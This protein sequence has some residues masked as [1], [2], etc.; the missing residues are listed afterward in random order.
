MKHTIFF[1]RLDGLGMALVRRSIERLEH[2]CD[3]GHHCLR[4]AMGEHPAFRY[5]LEPMAEMHRVASGALH[6]IT[7]EVG[8]SF[9]P[10]PPMDAPVCFR[11]SDLLDAARRHDVVTLLTEC[12]LG[13]R[14]LSRVYRET[15]DAPIPPH[16][17]AEI[18]AQMLMVDQALVQLRTLRESREAIPRS[19]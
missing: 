4:D 16:L 8:R 1:P 9:V 19:A 3:E 15:L 6:R 7:T 5:V 13:E 14:A 12:E 18:E 10:V 11:Y 17:A 2:A